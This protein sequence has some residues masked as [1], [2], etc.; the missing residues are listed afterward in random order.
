MAVITAT[1]AL[2]GSFA[3]S[4]YEPYTITTFAG[5]PRLYGGADGIGSAAQFFFPQ[6]VALDTTGNVY[7]ADQW[8]CTI[9]KITPD[10]VVTRLAG[11]VGAPGSQDGPVNIARFSYPQGVAV[12]GAGTVYV[13]DTGNSTIRK[14]TPGGVV[15]TLAGWP[16]FTGSLDGTGS[17]ARFDDPFSLAV[18]GA[19]YI[20]VADTDNSTIRKI[21]PEGTVSTLAGLAGQWGSADGTGSNA[22]F[23]GP[24]GVTVDSAGTVYVA[25]T[26][27]HTIRKVTSGGV[28]S[29]LAGLAPTWGSAD[30]PGSAARFW[31]PQDL[32][33]DTVGNVFVADAHNQTI[34]KV[35]LEGVVTTLAGSVTVSGSTDGAGSAA[36]FYAPRGIA[37]SNSGD[38]YIADTVNHTIRLGAKY[39]AV[40][41]KLHA[42]A[43]FDIVL[44]P[45]G[46]AGIECRS[47]GERGD[48]Q[49]VVN[50]YHAFTF[51]DASVTSGSGTV[52]S[53]SG[54][55]SASVVI[56]L[57]NVT[58]AQLLTLT[59]TGVNDGTITSDVVIP[60]DM[61]VGDTN[62]DGFVNAGDAVQ[63]RSRSGQTTDCHQL[64]LRCEC[65][66]RRQQRG[67]DGRARAIGHRLAVKYQGEGIPAACNDVD[68]DSAWFD[69]AS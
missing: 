4:T 25:D 57:A 39:G 26:G 46:V 10:G 59:L 36:Q 5:T 1:S 27:N 21:T 34:R 47:G 49:V 66:R 20:Y 11:I 12:D 17:G 62:G 7:I 24:N 65:G 8:N 44:P 18:D 13:A 28:V 41:R 35:S 56:D 40:S 19:G 2:N 37:V 60:I 64:P 30:G 16:G 9:R 42:G 32:A 68:S 53:A 6:A 3:Q 48:Y 22:R 23:G 29:T 38:L 55:G 52:V 14:I 61:L 45:Q 63:T 69:R 43:A 54:N 33:V 51:E 31:G 67:H 58:N 50:C 15:S